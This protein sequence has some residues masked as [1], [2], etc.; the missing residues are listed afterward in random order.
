[1]AIVPN[2]FGEESVIMMYAA[3]IRA[4]ERARARP[5]LQRVRTADSSM[6]FARTST[7]NT[8]CRLNPHANQSSP[9]FPART[10]LD[11]QA[12]AAS[13]RCCHNRVR[14]LMRGE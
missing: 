6:S 14:H 10:S 11:R 8:K 12:L 2:A 9:A 1:V 13:R 5:A 4:A 3:L 7:P